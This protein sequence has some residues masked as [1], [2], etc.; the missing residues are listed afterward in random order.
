LFGENSNFADV[1]TYFNDDSKLLDG[2]KLG[3]NPFA[4]KQYMEDKGHQVTIERANAD[5]LKEPGKFI[6]VYM[7]YTQK[8]GWGAHYMAGENNGSSIIVFNPYRTEANASDTQ[9]FFL[10]DLDMVTFKD[11]V[12]PL[13]TIKKWIPFYDE[14][15]PQDDGI[16]FVMRVD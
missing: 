1:Y 14:M 6:Y 13:T 7:W 16:G 9:Q 11:N 2:G 8:D 3:V 12:E 15:L 4:L 10:S 5:S